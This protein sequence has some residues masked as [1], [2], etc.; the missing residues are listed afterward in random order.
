M[1]RF[2]LYCIL[3]LNVG[4]SGAQ[5][6]NSDSLYHTLNQLQGEDRMNAY[7]SLI[8]NNWLNLPDKAKIYAKEAVAFSQQQDDIRLRAVAIRLLGGVYLYKGSYDSALLF[9]KEA[10]QLSVLLKD[11]SLISSG[12]NNIGF[13]HYHFSNYPLALENLLKALQIKKA[14]KQDYGL[15]QT[16]NNIGLVYTRLKDYDKARLHFSEAMAVAERLSD[17]HIALYSSNNIGFTYLEENQLQEAKKYFEASLLIATGVDNANW[18]A[19]AYSG[20]A[21]VVKREG[22]IKSAEYFLDKSLQL[23]NSIGDRRGISEIYYFLSEIR[24]E[25]GAYDEALSLLRKSQQIASAAKI[26]QRLLENHQ[27]ARKIFEQREQFDSALYYQTLFTQLRDS[28]FNENMARELVDIQLSQQEEEAQKQLASK[29][30]ELERKTTVTNYL[31]ITFLIV[32]LFSLA[33]YR[34][35]K[36]QKELSK[37]LK[38]TN[39]DLFNKSEEIQQQKESLQLSN[40]ELREARE[41]I[42]VQ[43]LQLEEL[44]RHLQNTVDLRTKE[45]DVAS[46][47]LRIVSLELDN[48]IYKSSHDIKGPLVRLLGICHVA[49]L[50]IQ[51]EKA[52]EYFS[53][54]YES[55]RHLND[56]FDRLKAVSDINASGLTREPINFYQLIDKV[57]DDLR[58]MEGFQSIEIFSEVEP[59]LRYESDPFLLETIFRNMLENAIRFQRKSDSDEKFIATRIEVKNQNVVLSFI[60]NGIGINEHAMKDIFKMFSKAA[61]EH[62]NVGLGLY[63][64]RQCVNKLEGTIRLV[65]NPKGYT[66]FQI[67]LPWKES[68]KEFV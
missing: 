63:I 65:K 21:Q 50:D 32:V 33:L 6:F 58:G 46:R 45:L 39:A 53:M 7:Q 49:L 4:Q 48:F 36:L 40:I 67:T 55:A 29:D 30:E 62:H 26:R 68:V 61:L 43:N 59:S 37:N 27:L 24:W 42:H 64:V 15:G 18:H 66:E 13:T 54:L 56:I 3:T 11:S 22:D 19:T 2:I 60:D 9:S 10:F 5:T 44:N 8:I 57:K 52:R 17:K 20:M 34:S 31:T 35:Y 25:S 47:E 41:R 12:Y 38:R 1:K 23:R 16:L 14:I 28:L 51:E